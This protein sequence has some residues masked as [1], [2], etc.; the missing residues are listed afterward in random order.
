MFQKARIRLTAW[1]LI[2][3]MAV[4]LMFS[5]IIYKAATVEITRFELRH[6][7]RMEQRLQDIPHIRIQ[8]DDN[9]TI[10]PF[11]PL[12]PTPDLIDEVKGRIIWLLFVL[13]MGILVVAGFLGYILAGRTLKPIKEMVDEQN[14]FI[15]DASHE[16]KTPLT[17]LKTAM[18]VHLREKNPK[19]EEMKELLTESITEVDRLQSLSESLLTLAQYGQPQSQITFEKNGITEIIKKSVQKVQ[20]LA[21][22]KQIEIKT[23]IEEVELQADTS[24]LTDLFVILLDNAVK[25]SAKKSEIEVRSKK[26]DGHVKISVID[27]GEGISE[28]DLPYIFDRFY[29]ADSARTKRNVGGYGLGLSIAK[30]I[31]VAHNGAISVIS[32]EKEGS[33]FEITLPLKQKVS[34]SVFS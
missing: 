3:I 17:S 16:L 23:D 8:I 26:T 10:A 20:P 7:M 22:Q 32:K 1:Y 18:E 31:A 28:K 12:P 9:P 5:S 15:S 30:K 34:R 14:R 4:S 25:Y 29:R 2:M 27:H 21:K 33:I 24:S 13:N 11:P 19:K 6:R